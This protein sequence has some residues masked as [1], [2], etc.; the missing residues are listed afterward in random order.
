[1]TIYGV[2]MFHPCLP[3]PYQIASRATEASTEVTPL[4]VHEIEGVQVEGGGRREEGGRRREGGRR[5]EGGRRRAG[6]SNAC[7]GRALYSIPCLFEGQCK[8]MI[9]MV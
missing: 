7:L 9:C 2:A 6:G 3:L 8:I 5:E 4:L 1:M